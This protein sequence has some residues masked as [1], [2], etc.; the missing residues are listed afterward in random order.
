MAQYQ[1]KCYSQK[2]HILFS[3]VQFIYFKAF[4]V[5]LL[6]DMCV[7]SVRSV[8]ICISANDGLGKNKKLEDVRIEGRHVYG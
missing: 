4:V 6:L 7:L 5:S 8:G 3:C 1:K 2:Y